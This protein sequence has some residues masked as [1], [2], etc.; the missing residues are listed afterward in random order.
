MK[1]QTTTTNKWFYPLQEKMWINTDWKQHGYCLKQI[2]T[3]S[4]VIENYLAKN[5]NE[6]A[7]LCFILSKK[8]N[9]INIFKEIAPQ[10]INELGGK[11]V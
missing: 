2:I 8:N 9:Q 3:P 6:Y 1:K 5:G 11:N 4:H 10:S 7:I